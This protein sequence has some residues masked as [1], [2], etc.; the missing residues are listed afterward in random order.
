MNDNNTEFEA[1]LETEAEI[2]AYIKANITPIKY[3][4]DEVRRDPFG[5]IPGWGFF[6]RDGMPS[7]QFFKR[8]IEVFE[9]ALIKYPEHALYI[10]TLQVRYLKKVLRCCYLIPK[11]IVE[12]NRKEQ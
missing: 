7:N 5:D 8:F 6:K 9:Q 10:S 3:M 12:Q 11:G 1:Q 2:R 4:L